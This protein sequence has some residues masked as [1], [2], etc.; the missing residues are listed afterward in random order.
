MKTEAYTFF[1]GTYDE[2]MADIPY[3]KWAG[4][5]AAVLKDNGIDGG[6]VLELGCGTGTFAALLAEYGYDVSGIDLSPSMI[7]VARRKYSGMHFEMADMREYRDDGRYNAVVS[8]CDSVNYLD[9]GNGLADMLANAAASLAMGGLVVFDLKTV[10][11]YEQLADN[12][13]TDEIPGCTYVWEN[14][15]DAGSR[16]NY[17]YLTFYRHIIGN[18]W[19]KHV[20][21]HVQYAFTHDEVMRAAAGAGLTVRAYLGEDMSG[22]PTDTENRVYYV[23]ERI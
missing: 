1:A 6:R 15:Y 11:F 17:Y 14:D 16:T 4:N 5:L 23:M 12:V 13:Y 10:H 21:E 2:F 18:L 3:D 19:K 8:V 20:E 7:K 22:A 9:G